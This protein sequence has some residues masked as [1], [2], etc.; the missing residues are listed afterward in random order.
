MK[1]YGIDLDGTLTIET[2]GWNY[3]D[4]TPYW[5]MINAVNELYF[6]GNHITLFTSRYPSDRTVTKRWL[7]KHGVMY[8]KLILGKP[9]FEIYIGDE[10]IT[11][12]EFLGVVST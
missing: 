9:K 6:S 1:R 3:A 8:N 11:P 12:Q 2:E 5:P 4:R 7:D 10:V